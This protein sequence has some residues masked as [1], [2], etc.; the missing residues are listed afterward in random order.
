MQHLMRRGRK[1]NRACVL[2][3]VFDLTFGLIDYRK[4]GTA[5]GNNERVFSSCCLEDRKDGV[6][7]TVSVF[8]LFFLPG[9]GMGCVEDLSRQG[10]W[11]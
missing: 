2:A 1:P 8:S 6:Q 5:Q 11:H 9:V 10:V 7:S 3:K 4:K